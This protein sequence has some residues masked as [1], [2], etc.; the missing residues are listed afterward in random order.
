[1]E[2][3]KVRNGFK[4]G[5]SWSEKA[6]GEGRALEPEKPDVRHFHNRLLFLSQGRQGFYREENP[7]HSALAGHK[8]VTNRTTDVFEEKHN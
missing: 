5:R 6:R 4:L 1:M 2:H 8:V 3:V 7:Q